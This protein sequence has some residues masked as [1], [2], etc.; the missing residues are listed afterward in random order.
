MCRCRHTHKYF[1]H[2]VW[3]VYDQQLLF[4]RWTHSCF[5]HLTGSKCWRPSPGCRPVT[6]K[7]LNTIVSG[8]TTHTSASWL[9]KDELLAKISNI[10]LPMTPGEMSPNT[11]FR[12]G[13]QLRATLTNPRL[14]L[15]QEALM[16]AS[17]RTGAENVKMIGG[18]CSLKKSDLHYSKSELNCHDWIYQTML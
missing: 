9:F 15:W 14:I 18:L 12:C 5:M 16:T 2:C 13:E 8:D 10:Y 6:A 4:R 17:G 3:C 1:T 11:S 7:E